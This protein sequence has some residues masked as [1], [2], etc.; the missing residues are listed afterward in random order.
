MISIKIFYAWNLV[1][2][3][4][5]N[6]KGKDFDILKNQDVNSTVAAT[7]NKLILKV[8]KPSE[9]FCIASCNSNSEC[10]SVFYNN[11]N[12][13]IP[14]CFL[15]NKYFN[16]SE[17]VPSNTAILYQKKQINS[18]TTNITTFS[19]IQPTVVL[20]STLV[21]TILPT[22]SSGIITP[23]PLPVTAIDTNISSS[24]SSIETTT[25]SFI[26][27]SMSSVAL[28]N[29]NGSFL[30]LFAN[31]VDTQL[32]KNNPTIQICLNLQTGLINN[33]KYNLVLD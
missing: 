13:L 23:T 30:E 19:P 4:T 12:A 18:L 6:S 27:K 31:G 21:R 1:V 8:N 14:N 22:F 5:A 11:K 10:V 15:Y 7:C 32:F 28:Q 2:V 24:V 29:S 17:L 20:T 16:S 9:I 3:L 33:M 25:I 26:S